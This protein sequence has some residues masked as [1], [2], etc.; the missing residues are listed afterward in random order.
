MQAFDP[1]LTFMRIWIRPFTLMRI[2]IQL[3][4][5]DP[6]PAF[7]FDSASQ[8]DAGP[9]PKHWLRCWYPKKTSINKK[10][11]AS[12]LAYVKKFSKY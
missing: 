1:T 8:N 5:L 10:G 2:W 9:D 7:H 6:D 4:T 11:I 3:L 12:S